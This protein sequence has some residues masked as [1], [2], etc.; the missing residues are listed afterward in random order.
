[1][2]QCELVGGAPAASDET[3]EVG[4]FAEDGIP[5]LSRTRILPEQIRFVFDALRNPGM[6]AAFD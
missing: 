2:F 1:M 4:F 5:E 6:P 3:S